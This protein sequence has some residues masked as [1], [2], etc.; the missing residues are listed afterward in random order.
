MGKIL[1]ERYIGKGAASEMVNLVKDK[2]KT[3]SCN[4]RG[5]RGASVVSICDHQSPSLNVHAEQNPRLA[6]LAAFYLNHSI[7]IPKFL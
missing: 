3:S 1:E 5:G 7:P 2:D 6:R 4:I